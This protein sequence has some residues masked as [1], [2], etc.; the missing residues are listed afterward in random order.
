MN[1]LV[2]FYSWYTCKTLHL[3]LYK[4]VEGDF[5]KDGRRKYF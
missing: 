4:A 5:T 3:F 2:H 1:F